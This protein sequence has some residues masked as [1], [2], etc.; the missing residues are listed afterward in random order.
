[1]QRRIYVADDIPTNIELVE[2]VLKSDPNIII[3]KALNGAD[4]L[5]IVHREGLPDLV[6]LDLMMP[7]KDGFDVIDALRPVRE[8]HY[9]PIIVL[10]ALTDKQNIVKA[11]SMGAD[12]YVIKPF[13]VAELKAR[14]SNM[15]KLKERDELLNRSIDVLSS[16]LAE[17]LELLEQTQLE[18]VIRLGRAAEFRD[19]ET[20]RHIERIS[21]YVALLTQ[22]LNYNEERS[23]MLKF[24]APMHDL[25]KIGIPDRI[26]LK[27]GK[28]TDEEFNVIK[29]HTLIG[30]RI[31]SG[32]TLPLLEMAREVAL[33]HH[34]RWDGTGY[35]FHLKGREIPSSGRLVAILDVFDALTS[36]RVYKSAWPFDKAFEYI[37]DQREKQFDPDVVDA[38]LKYEDRIIEIKKSNADEPATK[39]IIQS[40]ID[41][42][43]HLDALRDLWK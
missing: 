40:I 24:A 11:L 20:G 14:V 30:G 6:I 7:V 2:V 34:E 26:L 25:G 23:T 4:L 27:P 3:R 29:L 35:P 21:D 22:E 38:F 9:F 15:L 32:T 13:F 39:P 18:I 41:G 8:L 17:K 43:M 16:N 33:N 31:L 12:D 37:R 19:D 5:D 28:L 1:M 10:S 36:M 42:E